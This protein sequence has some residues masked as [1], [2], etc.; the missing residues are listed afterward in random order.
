MN[1]VFRG[2]SIIFSDCQMSSFLQMLSGCQV[3]RHNKNGDSLSLIFISDSI[4][5]TMRLLILII[6]Y[7]LAWTRCYL[8]VIQTSSQCLRLFYAS[9]Q[10]YPRQD[11]VFGRKKLNTWL[12]L[13]PPQKNAITLWCVWFNYPYKLYQVNNLVI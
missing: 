12:Q 7:L 3:T 11:I 2:Y 9:M 10:P 5:C 4:H 13:C 8:V 6:R 1:E